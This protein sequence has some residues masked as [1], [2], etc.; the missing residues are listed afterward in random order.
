[1]MVNVILISVILQQLVMTMTIQIYITCSRVKTVD[2]E[3][4]KMIPFR[5]TF[6][7]FIAL[8]SVVS[9]VAEGEED[10]FCKKSADDDCGKEPEKKFKKTALITGGAGFVAHHVIEVI[11]DC[12]YAEF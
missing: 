10:G 6:L 9:G 12:L 8:I 7:A 5:V 1:M 4:W 2:A 11:C 3:F